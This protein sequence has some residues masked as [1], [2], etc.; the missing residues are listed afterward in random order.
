MRGLASD[1]HQRGAALCLEKQRRGSDEGDDKWV[2]WGPLVGHA[3]RGG[4]ARRAWAR[5]QLGRGS[6]RL[7]GWFGPQA[8]VK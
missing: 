3:V 4:G 6:A 7:A 2:P 5:A 8:W 1:S